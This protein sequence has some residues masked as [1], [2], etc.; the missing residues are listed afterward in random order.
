MEIRHAALSGFR[1]EFGLAFSPGDKFR[2][3][4]TLDF[5]SLTGRDQNRRQ[6]TLRGW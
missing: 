4:E 5:G 6:R 3:N 1:S 2:L